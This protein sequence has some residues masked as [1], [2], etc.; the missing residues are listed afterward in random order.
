M[1]Q[2][3]KGNDFSKRLND[4]IEEDGAPT[5]QETKRSLYSDDLIYTTA[6]KALL[7]EELSQI[8]MEPRYIFRQQPLEKTVILGQKG[9]TGINGANEVRNTSIVTSPVQTV[10]VHQNEDDPYSSKY[11]KRKLFDHLGPSIVI[12]EINGKPDVVT[13]KM[14]ASEILHE[15]YNKPSETQTSEPEFLAHSNDKSTSTSDLSY[16]NNNF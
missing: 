4:H 11:M 2:N 14:T 3:V 5:K 16:S 10:T 13:F 6:A 1:L 7:N 12:A 9:Y 15:I 8:K